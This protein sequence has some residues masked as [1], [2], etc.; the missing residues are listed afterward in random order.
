MT[1]ALVSAVEIGVFLT[2]AFLLFRKLGHT[3]AEAGAYAVAL[4]FMAFSFVFQI[5]FL[6]HRPAVSTAFES[7]LLVFAV[8][9]LSRR[10][11]SLRETW[12]SLRSA[13]SGQPFAAAVLGTAFAFFAAAA[14]FSSPDPTRWPDI[15]FVLAAQHRGVFAGVSAAGGSPSGLVP[16]NVPILSHLFLRWESGMGTGLIGFLAYACIGFSTYAMARRY[17]WPPTAACVTVAVLSFPRFVLH[18]VSPG[19]EIVPAAFGA[20][21][22]LAMCRLVERLNVSD[23]ILMVLGLLFQITGTLTGFLFPLILGFLAFFISYQRHGMFSWRGLMRQNRTLA[24]LSLIPAL[25]FSQV[26]LFAYNVLDGNPWA[27]NPDTA[28]NRDGIYGAGANVIRY[29]IQAA[30]LPEP[31]DRLLNVVAGVGWTDMLLR[32]H[33]FLVEGVFGSRGSDFPF[34]LPA[35]TD[36]TSAW[37]GPLGFFLL[38][39]ALLYALFRGTSRLRAIAAALLGYVYAVCLIQAWRP[40]NAS[41]FSVVF[42]SGGFCIAFVLPPWRLASR[43][44]FVILLLGALLLVYSGTRL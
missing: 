30:Q 6:L 40:D 39:P 25:L 1:A 28:F 13:V 11:E 35:A 36:S 14:F 20:F 42:A 17:A 31:V 29:A 2:A 33:R 44:R 34:V 41:L 24:G 18:A 23:L 9:F 12:Q 38:W 3:A 19:S 5:A 22:V 43:G 26:W 21:C 7:I 8:F 4:V 32:L 10:K 15:S 27:G 16:M 37:F